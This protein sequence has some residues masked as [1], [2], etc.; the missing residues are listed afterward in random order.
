[1]KDKPH[2]SSYFQSGVILVILLFLTAVTV[3]VANINFGALSIGV[4]LLVA[5]IKGTIVLA[6]FMH[7]KF[8]KT[9]FRIMVIGVF[10][11][12]ALVI[13]ITF[14]DYLLR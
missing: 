1:M 5:S 13:G 3:I 9:F 6:Y 10:I 7:L 14:I 2:I 11:L 4:A 8:E 12:F